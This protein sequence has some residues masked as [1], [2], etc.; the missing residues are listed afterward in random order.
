M[1]RH[2]SDIDE[3]VR[4][5]VKEAGPKD[6]T[7]LILCMLDMMQGVSTTCPNENDQYLADLGM[8]LAMWKRDI[9]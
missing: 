3:E 6:L 1:S 4:K 8:E 7:H 5:V 2:I 9:V